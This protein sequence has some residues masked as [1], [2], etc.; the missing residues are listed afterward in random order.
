MRKVLLAWG[1][2]CLLSGMPGWTD[3]PVTGAGATAERTANFDV[4]EDK[5]IS[6]EAMRGFLERGTPEVYRGGELGRIE[7]PIGGIGNGGL[8]YLTGD[9]ALQIHQ[10]NELWTQIGTRFV[11][12]FAQD[13]RAVTKDLGLRDFPDMTFRGQYPVATLK[14]EAK[15]VPLEIGLEAFSPFI[16]LEA[17]DSG[18]PVT[19]FE[20]TL[21]NRSAAAVEATLA[22]IQENGVGLACRFGHAGERRNRVVQ[23]D[24]MTLLNCAV[25]ETAVPAGRPDIVFEDWNKKDYQGWIA[26][27]TAFGAKPM[28]AEEVRKPYWWWRFADV[29]LQDKG[30]AGYAIAPGGKDV[31]GQLTSAPFTIQRKYI[32]CSVGGRHE[33]GPCISLLIGGKEVLVQ[34]GYRDQ[35]FATHILDVQ[36][37]QGQTAQLR[38]SP[39][40]AGLFGVGRIVFSDRPGD[41]TPLAQRTDFGTMT[42][43]LLGAKAELALSRWEKQLQGENAAVSTV[44]LREPLAGMLGRAVTLQPGQST[45]VR[46][47]VCWHFPN[48]ELIPPWGPV[49]KVGQYYANRFKSAPE[50]A[51][52]MGRNI[53]RLARTTRLWR[54]TWYDSTLPY[55]FLDRTFANLSTLATSTCFRFADGRFYAYE[56]SPAP[57]YAGN[58]THVWHYAQGVARIFPELER[59]VAER[60][61]LGL[62]FN[63]QTGNIGM[64]GEVSPSPATDGQA[65]AILR[66]Y[67]E[68]LMSADDSFLKRNWPKIKLS[69]QPLFALDSTGEGLLDG[70]QP[71]TLDCIWY[72]KNSWISSLYVAALQAGERMAEIAGDA[73]FATKCR[74]IAEQG[75]RN[76]VAQLYNGEYF[77]SRIDPTHAN[78]MNSGNG[79]FIDQVLGQAWAWQLGLPRVTPPAE[80]KS[81]LAALWKYNFIPDAAPWTT[82]HRPGRVF[83][84]PGTSGMVMCTFPRADWDFARSAGPKNPSGDHFAQYFNE[85]WTGQEYQVAGHMIWEGM[86]EEGMAVIHAV[87]QRYRPTTRN[88][89]AEEEAGKHYARALASY[90]CFVAASGFTYDG[91]GGAIGFAPRLTPG[92]FRSAFVGAQGWGSYEQNSD[93]GALTTTIQVNYGTVR[94]RTWDCVPA[95]VAKLPRVEVTLNGKPLPAQAAERDAG[96]RIRL[97]AEIQLRPG[98]TLAATVK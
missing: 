64:R 9:G 87:H 23:A 15:D 95:A 49:G 58:C 25:E 35:R 77:N 82:A 16:P 75:S 72:G 62:G 85:V 12:K 61:N 28:T 59:D 93:A 19:M 60:V 69:F 80:T 33:G 68:H 34:P 54:D 41:G 90:G 42:L 52:Y 4:P 36:Q 20:F 70:A 65:G 91:P 89:W 92:K 81:A 78:T 5:G 8:I 50:V 2:G 46:F 53:E 84:W 29:Q 44:P 66:I 94:L 27:G 47:V 1:A 6:A 55:W 86:V 67:R 37:Y 39:K 14:Y 3:E 10:V 51:A 26:E 96:V 79:S 83:V 57:S 7:M 43:A 97:A 45:V 22:G 30:A 98:D 13:G 71:N 76:L 73:E 21:K 31:Q 24:G 17:A 48:L 18:L 11:V 56:G 40:P 32:N 38:F 88:P 63:P 74:G